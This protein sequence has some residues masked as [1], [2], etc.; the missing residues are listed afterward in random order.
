MPRS[1]LSISSGSRSSSEESLPFHTPDKTEDGKPSDRVTN[2]KLDNLTSKLFCHETFIS[3]NT[4]LP[5]IVASRKPQN[6][7][8]IGKYKVIEQIGS[9]TY[10]HVQK[11]W[12]PDTQTYVAIKTFVNREPYKGIPQ[13]TYREI[14]A[15]QFKS[16][17]GLLESIEVIQTENGPLGFPVLHLVTEFIDQ[18]LKQFIAHYPHLLVEQKIKSIMSQLVSAVAHLNWVLRIMHRDLKPANILIS[19]EG[20]IKIADFGMAKHY[21]YMKLLTPQVVTLWYRSPEILMNCAY[22][23]AVDVWSLGCVFAELYNKW[24]L[25]EG[26]SE[27]SQLNII[28]SRL[29]LPPREKWPSDSPIQYEQFVDFMPIPLRQILHS[30]PSLA[31]EAIEAM[32][33]FDPEIRVRS[34]Q[35]ETLEFFK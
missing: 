12:D 23:Y 32:L 15:F 26:N 24:P 30:A 11:G 31:L 3:H 35:L 18:D 4:V 25:F 5:P 20:V 13:H 28:I 17:S 22:D 34:D 7:K 6:Y 29:G 33:E 1:C 16:H 14:R 10:G 27:I 21:K 9:G 2:A 19:E 8:Y